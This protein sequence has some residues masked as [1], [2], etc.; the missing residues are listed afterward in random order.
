MENLH[1]EEPTE[2]EVEDG[3]VV[4]RTNPSSV[5]ASGFQDTQIRR[6]RLGTLLIYEVSEYE[7][8]KIEQGSPNSTYFNFAIFLISTAVSF[9]VTLLTATL[10]PAQS[11][12]FY[13]FL[14]V[15][16]VSWVGGAV[17]LAL[18]LRTKNEVDHVFK[19]IKERAINC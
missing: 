11:V 2:S 14:T 15:T 19:R 3:R 1:P 6:A 5:V 10:L 7:L 8:E 17:L 9:T 16:L 13:T 4:V 18:W 12:V